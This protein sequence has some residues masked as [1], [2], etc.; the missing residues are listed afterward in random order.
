[1][2]DPD[3]RSEADKQGMVIRTQS[4]AALDAVVKQAA[5]APKTVLAK[6]ARI[7]HWN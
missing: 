7:L 4:G 6:T 2:K 1:M 5:A 3:F